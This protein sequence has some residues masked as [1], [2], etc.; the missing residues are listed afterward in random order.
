[1]GWC[2]QVSGVVCGRCCCP[3]CCVF[4]CRRYVIIVGVWLLL[5]SLSCLVLLVLL[6]SVVFGVVCCSSL[7]VVGCCWLVM[8]LLLVC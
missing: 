7:C 6:C 8:A 3:G 2:V 5:V 4:V 1:M